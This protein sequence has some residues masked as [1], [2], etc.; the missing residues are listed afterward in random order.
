MPLQQESKIP[1]LRD[2]FLHPK[3]DQATQM[4]VGGLCKALNCT[5][6]QILP[7]I[8]AGYIKLISSGHVSSLSQIESLPG[9]AVEWMRSWLL[10]VSAKPLL[11]VENMADLLNIQMREV[12]P[13][14]AKHDV[15][16]LRDPATGFV[17]SIWSARTLLLRS[18]RS[19]EHATRFDR[20]AML[21]RLL[22]KDPEKAAQPPD[23]DEELEKEM[24]RVAKLEEPTRSLRSAEIMSALYDANQIWATRET[25]EVIPS[26]P[27][28]PGRSQGTS[29]G[30]Q[31]GL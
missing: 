16:V 29:G 11:S 13:L 24:E 26:E 7:F 20:Q 10:P 9:P 28:L 23:F 21:W 8:Q 22:E 17:F 5:T 6:S 31:L 25:S 4:S 2:I 3:S 12:L 15:P 1:L 19:R 30:P 18:I 14:A 27:S